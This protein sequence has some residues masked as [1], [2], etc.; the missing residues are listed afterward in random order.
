MRATP[1]RCPRCGSTRSWLLQGGR[2]RC[3]RCRYDWK[4]GRLPLHLTD[5]QWRDLLGWFTR[6]V[7][8]A[9]IARETGLE[10]RRVLRAVTIVRS[11]I[12]GPTHDTPRATPGESGAKPVFG[13]SVDRGRAIA[14]VVPEPEADLVRRLVRARRPIAAS[15][16]STR[17]AAI[18][19][20]GR[21][22]RLLRDDR[23]S[24]FGELEAF[25]AYLQ[26]RLRSKGGIRRARIALYLAE[27]AWRYNNRAR[28]AHDQVREL[29]ALLR[30]S[31]ARWR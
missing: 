21:F 8:S 4:P 14:E 30:Q 24:A 1:R 28:S 2:R 23:D 29:L 13:I 7:S 25:W 3:V 20:R 18:V 6:G 16:G 31:G 26:Q 10:R 19:Y 15:I 11:A 27:Y 9:Q 22:H 5:R 12:A 17:Y